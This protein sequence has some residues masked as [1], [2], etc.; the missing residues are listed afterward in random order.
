M[1]RQYTR[2]KVASSR[3]YTAITEACMREYGGMSTELLVETQHGVRTLTLNRPECHNA[4]NDELAEIFCAAFA[5]AVADQGVR[6]ILIAGAGKS[7][8]SGRDTRVL[9]HRARSESDFEF[10]RRHQEQRLVMLNCPKPIVTALKGAAL[11]GGCELA[12]AADIRVADGTLTMGMP[13]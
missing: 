2:I 8:C 4:F 9:G 12:L 11:G 7:F 10:V 6:A 3:D 5:E 13:E 1:S